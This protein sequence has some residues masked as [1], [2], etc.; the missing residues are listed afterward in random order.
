MYDHYFDDYD[1][2][3]LSGDDTHLIVE[4]LRHSVQ[5]TRQTHDVATTPIF[6]GMKLKAG[7]NTL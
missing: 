7:G 4:N 5:R 1:Y 3:Y 6:M 2:F